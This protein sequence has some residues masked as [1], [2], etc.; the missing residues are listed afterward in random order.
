MEEQE[1]KKNWNA[2]STFRNSVR[3]VAGRLSMTKMFS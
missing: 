3:T 2:K 1:N